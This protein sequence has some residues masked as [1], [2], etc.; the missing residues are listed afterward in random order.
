M[1]C[2]DEKTNPKQDADVEMKAEEP[3]TSTKRKAESNSEKIANFSRVTPV[4]LGYI[5]FPMEGRYQPIRPVASNPLATK[6]AK[7]TPSPVKRSLASERY[8][9]GGGILI[10]VDGREGEEAELIDLEPPAMAAGEIPMQNGFANAAVDQLHPGL[11][12]SAPE[13]DPP[14]PFEVRSLAIFGPDW[15][16]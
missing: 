12:A 9:G 5:T 3:S 4:Q 2:K 10:L 11:D 13:A 14:E 6:G 15:R 8:A 1:P 16:S 7:S